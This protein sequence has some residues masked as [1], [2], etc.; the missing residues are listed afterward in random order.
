M[1]ENLSNRFNVLDFIITVLKQHEKNLDESLVKLE[2]ILQQLA[3]FGL[4]KDRD[5]N[6]LNVYSH[7]PMVEDYKKIN[8]RNALKIRNHY[9]EINAKNYLPR[10]KK[11]YTKYPLNQI[12]HVILK[13][14]I[15]K[16]SIEEIALRLDMNTSNVK[17]ILEGLMRK[18]YLPA[19]KRLI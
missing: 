14:T 13:L 15:K 4:D 5:S 1:E 10:R 3:N 17:K 18:G 8:N 12:E 7:F 11:G 2:T 9:N 16:K 19:D 6:S